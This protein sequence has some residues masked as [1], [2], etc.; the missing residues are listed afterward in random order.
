MSPG[1]T[2]TAGRQ[3]EALFR[4][5]T[6]GAL[7][8]AQL[9][10]QFVAHRGQDAE[11]AF[12]AIV[13]RHGPMVFSVCRRILVDPNDAEDAFQVTFLVLARKARATAWRASLANWLYGVAVRTAKEV[14]K[15][16]A[17][18]RAR[19]VQ[20]KQRTRADRATH[21]PDDELRAALDLELSRL[22]DQFRA[23]IVLC[24]LEGK[25]H[26]EAARVLGVPVGTVSS[27][28]VR[29]RHRL[30]IRLARR[31][32]D[33]SAAD[34]QGESTPMA[35]PPALI[36]ATSRAAARFAA[37]GTL[38]G[39]APA[40]LAKLTDGVLKSMLLAKLTSKAMIVSMVLS[41]SM[42]AAGLGVVT[43]AWQGDGPESFSSAGATSRDWAWV[44][45]L[46]NADLA[47]K[48]RLKRCASAA[49]VNFAAIHRLI[50]D[51]DLIG[52]TPQLPLDAAGKLKGV[53]RWFSSG[54]VYWK[55]G[56]GR[57]E[58]SP[59][60]TL[61]AQG[62]KF[63]YKR[64]R[65]F[66][67]VRSRDVL[68]YTELS[69]TWGLFLTV[70]NPP[71]SA[72]EWERSGRDPW[73]LDPSLHYAQPFCG[74]GQQLRDY[75]ENCRAIESEEADGKV[76]L[77]FLHRFHPPGG[78]QDWRWEITCDGAA[79]WLPVLDRGGPIRDGRWMIE[80]STTS[81]W[82]KLS[83]VWYPVHQVK[84]S[85]FGSE[86]KPVKEIDRTVRRLRAN[87]AVNLPDSAFTLSVM[88]IPEG[89]PGLDRRNEPFR[90]LIRAG[91][92]VRE[93]R[94]GEGR[95]PRNVEQEKIERQKD[96][97]TIAAEEAGEFVRNGVTAGPASV[98]TVPAASREYAALL[99]EYD[100][101]RRA[102]EKAFLDSKPGEAQREAYLAFGRLDWTYAPK[103]LELARKYPGD[104]V[105][106]DALGLLV[107]SNFTPPESEQAADILIRDQLASDKLIA[108]YRQLATTLNPA[109]GSAAERLLRA[110][111]E[112][113]PTA[114]A[115]AF[116]CLKLADRLQYRADAVR[117]MRGPEPEPFM[118]LEELARAG[119]R[120]PVR[121]TEEDPDALTREAVQLY[122]RVVERYSDVKDAGVK[123]A[124]AHALFHL[125]DLAVGKPAP[126]VDGLDVDGKP[127]T[128]SGQRGKVVVLTFSIDMP[129]P[130]RD[131][132][133]RYRALVER[134]KDRPF[135]LLSVNL[136]D[137]KETLSKTIT[138][139]EITW[140]CWWE[141]G[142]ERPN[143]D[144]WKVSW[145]PSV[146]VID[147]DGIIRAKQ[148]RGKALD[149]AV[150]AL[151]GGPSDHGAGRASNGTSR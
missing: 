62:R 24:D 4:L 26:K 81:E 151:L 8:D 37:E 20:M 91:G 76:L 56:M 22:P 66:S 10:E 124:A 18:R 149:Q 148:V 27:R 132:Y 44:D 35:V 42:G 137:K 113:G 48:E 143:C 98:A 79:D 92:V 116:A 12:A 38:A 130:C 135:V 71:Q 127:L 43:H 65:G 109:P 106:I 15:N 13:E 16:A 2:N 84:M 74:H 122:G 141:G 95:S 123:D 102:R 52:E 114:E 104:P 131:A 103:F 134:M 59:L 17:R 140:R 78:A 138:A 136:D 83:G 75:W 29:A 60:G 129:G 11:D 89:T 70:T 118:K 34:T 139:G 133:P 128:L 68:A 146:Y 61:D 32:L 25:T 90:W 45:R 94:P 101:E 28:L 5:G 49:T 97:E 41:L 105:A 77:R 108:I 7:T 58:H 115:R 99:E 111:A 3:L 55:D 1:S 33:P 51:Y 96:E 88:T 86:L 87:G 119:G 80:S 112:K 107:S 147:A 144:R 39:T 72:L 145:I 50:F 54:T 120:E 82:Q 9:M 23:P 31:G 125:R 121:R 117:T 67:V 14:R 126:E 85:Y 57:Y 40:Y 150:D 93:V 30:R 36:A 47:T 6:V 21:Q 63:V 110:A 142:E 46:A 100:P 64:P 69:P 73:R 19:E 53:D